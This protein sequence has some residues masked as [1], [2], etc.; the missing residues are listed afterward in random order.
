MCLGRSCCCAANYANITNSDKLIDIQMALVNYKCIS[1]KYETE[2]GKPSSRIIEP[3]MLYHNS[4]ED[5]VLA[6]SCRVRKDFRS[7]RLDRIQNI[8]ILD[9]V[10]EPHKLTMKQYV[11]KYVTPYYL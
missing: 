8:E 4:T 6:A 3:Y 10:F 7:F 11:K 1:V 2:S 5:W 9:D